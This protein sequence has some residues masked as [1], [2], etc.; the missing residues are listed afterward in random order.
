M[1]VEL[2]RVVAV[3]GIDLDRRTSYQRCV[4]LTALPP[5]ACDSTLASTCRALGE[6]Q[7]HLADPEKTGWMYKQGHEVRNWKRCAAPPRPRPTR[8]L[9]PAL[10]PPRVP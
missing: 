10:H 9:A 3:V 4:R 5:G 2:A 1:P 6:R 7:Q 8:P